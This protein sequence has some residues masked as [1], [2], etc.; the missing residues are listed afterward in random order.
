MKFQKKIIAEYRH[1]RSINSRITGY[2]NENISGVKIVKGLVREERNLK[3]FGKLT[4]DMY[5]SS[6]R[7]VKLSSIFIPLVQVISAI[8]FGIVLVFGGSQIQAGG[9][10]TIGSLQAFILYV[11]IIIEPINVLAAVFA[12]S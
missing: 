4:D 6:Y 9:T 5:K 7:A 1:V 2:Y 10:F 12:S 3:K 11:T 8:A